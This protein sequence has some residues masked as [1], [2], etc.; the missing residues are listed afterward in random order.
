MKENGNWRGNRGSPSDRGYGAAWGRLRKLVMARDLWL[1]QPCKR[2][3][4]I[5]PA[6]EAD[7]IV[8][9]SD[10]G[11]DSLENIQAICVPCHRAKTQEEAA[12]AQ[13]R[14]LRPSFG[15]DGWPE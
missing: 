5:T 9:K 3:G 11:G 13:G 2:E 10:G 14:R 4:R 8:P 6:R 15:V 7:H 1:C 12:R